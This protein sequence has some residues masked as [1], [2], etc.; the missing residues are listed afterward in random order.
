M[1]YIFNVADSEA[2]FRPYILAGSSG[3]V[4]GGCSI[5]PLTVSGKRIR[6][7]PE[8]W[9][10]NFGKQ[11]YL[12]EKTMEELDAQSEEDWQLRLEGQQV[13][14][15]EKLHVTGYDTLKAYIRSEL[16]SID[17]YGGTN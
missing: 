2:Y 12:H 13:E 8:G 15:G 1:A 9:A 3:S 17:S 7:I 6:A 4:E 5:Q 16:H 14:I 10:N 11:F